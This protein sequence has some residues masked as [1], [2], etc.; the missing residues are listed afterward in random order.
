[1]K[2]FKKC[3]SLILVVIMIATCCSGLIASAADYNHLPKIYVQ[4]VGSRTVYMADDPEKKAVFFPMNSEVLMENL[5]NFKKYIEDSAKNLDPDIIYNL[6]YNLM[7]DTCGGAVLDTDGIS[8]KFNSTIDP[9][10]LDY[11]GNGEYYFNYD[12]RLD[13]VDIAHQLYEYI[14]WVQEHSGSEKY[15]LVGSSYG[16]ASLVACLKEYPDIL[17]DIDSVLLCVPT[18]GGME[19]VGELFSGKVNTDAVLLKDYLGNMLGNDDLNLLLSILCHTGTL[20]FVVEEAL[21][22]AVKAALLKAAKDIVHDIFATF[23]S[24]WSYIKDENF[25]EALEYLYGENYSDE[26]HEYAGL[27]RRV[28][29]YHEEVMM[30]RDEIFASLNEKG[31]HTAVLVKYDVPM[32][33]LSEKG[34]VMG[35]NLVTVESASFGATACRYGET[36]PENYQQ[37]LY[38]EYNMLSPDRCIDASTGAYPFT[39]WYIK[40]LDHGTITSGYTKLMNTVAYNNLDVFTDENYP[41]FMVLGE[42]G[43]SVLPNKQTEPEKK[44]TF[45]EECIAFLKRIVQIITE[46]VKEFFTK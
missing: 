37:K 27:I 12:S 20:D 38:T 29:Y 45:L 3:I 5:K 24:M 4:G 34:N 7:W 28:T 14:G 31:I 1:M 35:D 19:F 44:M 16:T 41:Q 15:E 11:R 21:E 6:A 26:D 46:K 40:G 32:I 22:P 30:K 18:V 9:C 17:E 42:D 33:P 39:T 23:P 10:P 8:P 2:A 36:F 43:E 13:P 25:Y